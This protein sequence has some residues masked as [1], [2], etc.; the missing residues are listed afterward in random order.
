[1]CEILKQHDFVLARQ[2]GSHRIMQKRVEGTTLTVPV[3]LH[4]PLRRGTLLSI[5][6]QS[7]LAKG[8]FETD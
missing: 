2:R 6:R 3:P 8:L 7:G 1:M 4:D 5:I